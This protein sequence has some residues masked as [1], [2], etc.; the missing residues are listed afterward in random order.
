MANFQAKYTAEIAAIARELARKNNLSPS[1]FD[2]IL[3][4][5]GSE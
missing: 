1:A 5:S 3:F 4:Y 2:A